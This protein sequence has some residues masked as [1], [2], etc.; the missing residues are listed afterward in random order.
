MKARHNA[1]WTDKTSST[2]IGVTN[3]QSW[4]NYDKERSHFT[5]RGMSIA[6]RSWNPVQLL[7]SVISL[8]F[9]RFFCNCNSSK[10]RYVWT[11][12]ASVAAFPAGL[13]WST[14]CRHDLSYRHVHAA[15]DQSTAT[16]CSSTADHRGPSARQAAFRCRSA[17]FRGRPQGRLSSLERRPR[18]CRRRATIV[19][20]STAALT[21]RGADEMRVAAG[22]CRQDCRMSQE[23]DGDVGHS[24]RRAQRP[25]SGVRR[26]LPRPSAPQRS[27]KAEWNGTPERNGARSGRLSG[28]RQSR[29]Q[30]RRH[31][32]CV[33]S[34]RCLVWAGCLGLWFQWYVH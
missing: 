9:I 11:S 6:Q 14:V 3:R 7:S 2:F 4:H 10:V 13:L 30:F 27:R 28:S 34:Q 19:S 5:S 26:E 29:W 31:S 1:P 25:V 23:L 18:H 33:T 20:S 22:R 17:A 32:G 15:S 24:W 8:S 12:P 16:R 21:T